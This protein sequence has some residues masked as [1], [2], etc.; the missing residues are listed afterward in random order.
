MVACFCTV[1]QSSAINNLSTA[2]IQWRAG[3][4]NGTLAASIQGRRAS[5]Q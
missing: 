2:P 1:E 4:A 5:K 3:E